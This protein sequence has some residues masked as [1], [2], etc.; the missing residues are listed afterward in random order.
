MKNILDVKEYDTIICNLDY[1][2]DD[3]YK[4]LDK[5]IFK[6]LDEFIRSYSSD[7]ENVD[8]SDF[9]K[10]GYKKHIGSTISVKNYVGIIQ[11][12]DGFQI[13]VLP[14]ISFAKGIDE[15]NSETKQVFLRM[16]K[17]MKDFPA[18]HFNEANLKID[19]MN[20][21]EVFIN[22][23]LQEV[24]QLVKRGIKAT[25]V[26]AE[27][28][29]N[30]F[31]GKLIVGA[32]LKQNIVHRERFFVSYDEYHVNRAENKLIK[33]TLIKLHRLSNSSENQKL[34]QKL[35]LSFE[36][37]DASK[38]YEK[39]FDKVVI[40]R[41][42][43]EYEML[44]QWSRVFLL[45]K[46]FTTFSGS[47]EARALLFSMEKV[48]ESYVAQELRKIVIKQGWQ[49]STQ[50]KGRYLFESQRRFALRPDIVLSNDSGRIVVMDT[51][52]KSLIDNK[53]KNYGI[54][55]ADMYQMYAYSKK[56]NAP[57]IWLLYPINDQMR[58]HD[59]IS[60][61]GIDVKLNVFFVDVE[62][63]SDSLKEL[64]MMLNDNN[65]NYWYLHES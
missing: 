12:N 64:V 42:T 65:N 11:M 31:K 29:L 22:M 54:S 39:D 32:H 20:L 16:L 35:L 38:N 60:F 34:I 43:Q 6:K 3:R 28:N 9:L 55:Q 25:Y 50:D 63:I 17:S 46:S 36:I 18:K 52:W 19:R 26:T 10:I 33:S 58:N 57:E 45:N 51:K 1:K 47:T 7:E 8:A 37:V 15:K 62:K 56:Y 59:P 2:D 49:I 53:N 27:D 44:M 13:Q 14:K 40:D 4:Y 21:Y 23:Y 30:Y 48:F 5:N 41:N 61:V 24:T